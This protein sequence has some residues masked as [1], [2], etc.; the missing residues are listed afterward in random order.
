MPL[1]QTA[2]HNLEQRFRE[3]VEKDKPHLIK[4]VVQGWGVYLP[5]KE[6]K[7]QVDYIIVGMEPSFG[8]WADSIEAAEKKIS[9]GFRN[10]RPQKRN[11]PLAL[12]IRSIER[13]LCQPGETYHLTDVSKGAM[14]VTV[15]DLDRER[16]YEN[17]LPLLLVEIEIV[18]KYGAPVIAIGKDVYKFLQRH[19]VNG[20]TGRRLYT[21]A[22][23]S[24]QAS[25]HH[26]KAATDNYQEFERFEKAELRNGRRWPADLPPSMKHLVFTYKKQFEGIRAQLNAGS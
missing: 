22:H 15:A 19:D 7:T 3:Q 25:G 13:F 21:V 16:R 17:W 6:P 4:R 24:R 18:G 5:C 23:Y 26:K 11:E 10:F 14:L 12:F 1:D 20:K 8:G 2:Y 9:K